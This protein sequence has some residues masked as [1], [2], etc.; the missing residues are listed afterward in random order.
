MANDPLMPLESCLLLIHTLTN[1][2]DSS[3]STMKRIHYLNIYGWEQKWQVTL[4]DDFKHNTNNNEIKN[5]N[6]NMI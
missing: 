1:E 5:I 3:D 6:S 4:V 2:K